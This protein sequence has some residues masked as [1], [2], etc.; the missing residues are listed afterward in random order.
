MRRRVTCSACRTHESTGSSDRAR[1]SAVERCGC[2]GRIGRAADERD[3]RIIFLP[4]SAR[5]NPHH[6]RLCRLERSANRARLMT[7]RIQPRRTARTP[8]KRHQLQI[9]WQNIITTS[10]H[11]ENEARMRRNE[12]ETVLTGTHGRCSRRRVEFCNCVI[13]PASTNVILD[14]KAPTKIEVKWRMGGL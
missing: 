12:T 10:K 14:P 4:A 5:K 3:E 2:S 6:Q 7:L 1:T 8:L 11:A 13:V 9:V